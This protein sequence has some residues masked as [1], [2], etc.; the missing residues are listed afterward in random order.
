MLAGNPSTK[1]AGL[2]S[3]FQ[4]EESNYMA[5]E[6][7][8][9]YYLASSEAAYE[10]PGEQA[11]MGFMAE[12]GLFHDGNAS[13]WWDHKHPHFLSILAHNIN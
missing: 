4:S 12:R 8:E 7:M 13:Q 2:G 10:D 1:M 9:E 3:K 5:A 11:P 6:A